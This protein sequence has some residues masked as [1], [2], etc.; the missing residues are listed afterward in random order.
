VLTAYDQLVDWTIP[1]AGEA[2][3]YMLVLVKETETLY[4]V[5]TRYLSTAVVEVCE[6]YP[7]LGTR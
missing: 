5:L 1:A 2:N 6:P 7:D 3:D 4:K